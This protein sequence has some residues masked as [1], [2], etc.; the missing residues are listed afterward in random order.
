MENAQGPSLILG[1]MG[2]ILDPML[3]ITLEVPAGSS[4]TPNVDDEVLWDST[5]ALPVGVGVWICEREGSEVELGGEVTHSTVPTTGLRGESVS[6]NTRHRQNAMD[7][8]SPGS[9]RGS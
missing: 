8:L 4:N 6:S 3:K 2:S 9:K 5:L 7:L 1:R